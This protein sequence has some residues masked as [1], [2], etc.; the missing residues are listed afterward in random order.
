MGGHKLP[1]GQE[2]AVG[3]QEHLS[4]WGRGHGMETLGTC[5]RLQL[6]PLALCLAPGVE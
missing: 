5:P 2:L 1:Q 4:V 3:V 6:Q